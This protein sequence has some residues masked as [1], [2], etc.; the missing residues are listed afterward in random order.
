MR[1]REEIELDYIDPMIVGSITLLAVGLPLV[2][3]G[4][5]TR[6]RD[7]LQNLYGAAVLAGFAA[8]TGFIAVSIGTFSLVRIAFA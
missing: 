2:V 6:R 5:Y 7:R 3:I 4:L 1:N 8:V